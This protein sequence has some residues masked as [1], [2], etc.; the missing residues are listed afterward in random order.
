MKVVVNRFIL[1]YNL[2]HNLLN[3]LVIV[4]RVKIGFSTTELLFASDSN[5]ILL[6]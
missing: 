5:R 4:N 1:L 3:F 6:D 2:F